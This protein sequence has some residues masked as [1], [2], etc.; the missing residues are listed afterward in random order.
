M[1]S[2]HVRAF[3]GRNKYTSTGVIQWMLNNAWPST[4]W[5]LYDWYLRP[6]GGYFGTKIANER[7]HAQYSYDDQSIA[8]VNSYYRAFPNLK[9]TAKVYNLDLTEKYT[10]TASVNVGEDGVV[11]AFTLPQIEGLSKT[12][13]VKL[14]L[15][16]ADGKRIGN[17]FYWLSTQPDVN[18]W[19]RGNG[20]YTPIS[21]YADLT[22]L[23]DLPQAKVTATSSTEA[24]GENQVEHV[25]LE[26]PSAHLA[27][28]VHLTVLRGKGG[29]DVKPILWDDNYI[30]LMPGEKREVTA[31][32]EKKQLMGAVPHIRVDGFNVAEEE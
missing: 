18:N 12:Y 28:F 27:F 22:G 16:G 7:L 29:E 5:H 17:N 32:F 6:G 15:D 25:M 8:V 10:K 13:F 21:T 19:Q 31:T 26:N 30:T 20:V 9:V 3:L 2:R 14:T 4:I 24:K 1:A 11:K 23:Q